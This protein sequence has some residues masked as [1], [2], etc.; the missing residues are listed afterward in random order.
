MKFTR[1]TILGAV[2]LGASLSGITAS[3]K[4]LPTREVNGRNYYYYEV[5]P[6]ETVYSICHR[7]GITKDELVKSNPSVADGLRWGTVLFF[8]V[9]VEQPDASPSSSSS[10]A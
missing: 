9:D 5:A 2:A 4:D 10:A 8:P 6:K 1:L 3:I 7:L